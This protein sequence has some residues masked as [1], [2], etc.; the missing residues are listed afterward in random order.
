MKITEEAPIEVQVYRSPLDAA[1]VVQVDTDNETGVVR[2]NLNDAAVWHGDPEKE[3]GQGDVE[4]L[5]RLRE[6]NERLRGELDRARRTIT[7]TVAEAGKINRRLERSIEDATQ[8]R[9]M[10]APNAHYHTASDWRIAFS[11]DS[12][13]EAWW[14]EVQLLDHNDEDA[15]EDRTQR[16][17][18]V[19]S[20]I[21]AMHFAYEVAV[22]IGIGRERFK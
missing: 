10:I 4:E 8:L 15:G 13:S 9:E 22:S 3:E 6:E 20:D 18:L 7:A 16:G 19:L 12:S 1:L 5:I 14:L 2:I 17:V 21:E 11:E